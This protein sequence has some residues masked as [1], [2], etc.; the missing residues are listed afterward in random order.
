MN[1]KLLYNRIQNFVLNPQKEWIS[2]KKENYEFKA[3]FIDYARPL[4]TLGA[5]TLFFRNLFFEYSLI[6][7]LLTAIVYFLSMF[8]SM[9]IS[10]II[11]TEF[12]R[13]FGIEK[14][15]NK[16]V[17]LVIYSS[18]AFY[19]VQALVNLHQQLALLSIFSIYT[20][21]LFWIGTGV[22]YDNF[23]N[24]KMAFVLLSTF[25]IYI[26]FQLMQYLLSPFLSMINNL[27]VL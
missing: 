8:G 5:V 27:N 2:I 23:E 25:T 19:L 13:N 9:Y 16:I 3:L 1:L 24:R 26:S 11:I 10:V 4:I 21:Y 6:G 20:I 12:S 18:L 15:K 7:N 17:N 22:Y 14:N